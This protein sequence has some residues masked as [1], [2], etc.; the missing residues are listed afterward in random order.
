[1][2]PVFQCGGGCVGH[3]DAGPKAKATVRLD[4]TPKFSLV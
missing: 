2:V 4:G 3:S 1:M